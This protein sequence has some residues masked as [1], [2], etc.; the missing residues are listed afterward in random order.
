MLYIISYDVSTST[1]Q[2]KKRLRQVAKVCENHGIR[3]QNSVFECEMPY[4][5]FLSLKLQLFDLIDPS[6]DSLRFYPLGKNGRQHVVHLGAKI[7]LD[8]KAPLI[9]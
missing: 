7:A 9:L 3:V 4:D 6:V 5:M 8:V 1:P 2:G